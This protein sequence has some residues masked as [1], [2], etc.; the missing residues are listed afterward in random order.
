[1]WTYWVNIEA[2]NIQSSPSKLWIFCIYDECLYSQWHF[3]SW[4]QIGTWVHHRYQVEY[5]HSIVKEAGKR[6]SSLYHS[7]KCL[8]YSI[9]ARIRTN[10][11]WNVA[12]I[13][14]LDFPVLTFQPW[15]S[16]F[17][18]SFSCYFS[19][20]ILWAANFNLKPA[21]Y[22][23]QMKHHKSIT[24]LSLFP[25]KMFRQTTFLSFTCS[26]HHCQDPLCCMYV[27]ITLFP[28][29]FHWKGGGP[30][31]QILPENCYFVGQTPEKILP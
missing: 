28:F 1:M 29:I 6:V 25:W 5:I 16:F 19:L 21:A 12:A 31:W 2:G 15:Q 27:K 9:V 20:V 7:R 24:T 13:C 3:W 22:F 26:D 18:W 17:F 11:K 30:T 4:T 14:G 8:L 23:P 10:Q